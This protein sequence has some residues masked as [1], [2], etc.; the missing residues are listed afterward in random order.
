MHLT[1]CQMH[2]LDFIGNKV[3]GVK[4][5]YFQGYF[6]CQVLISDRVYYLVPYA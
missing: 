2:V 6:A 5:A 1:I 4:N 3:F